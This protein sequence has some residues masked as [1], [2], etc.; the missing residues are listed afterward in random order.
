[1]SKH[2]ERIGEIGEEI[3]I[4]FDPVNVFAIRYFCKTK[5]GFAIR[6]IGFHNSTEKG[7]IYFRICL[8]GCCFGSCGTKIIR[9]SEEDYKDSCN[10]E[11]V[12][13]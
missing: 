13:I 2:V 7:M 11:R 9:I 12:N 10:K 1:M 8:V 5:D 4:E 3:S 6:D